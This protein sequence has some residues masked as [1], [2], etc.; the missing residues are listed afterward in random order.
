MY[1]YIFATLGFGLIFYGL[2]PLSGSKPLT[3]YVS[4]YGCLSALLGIAA[5]TIIGCV[6]VL[7]S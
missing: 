1:S 4:E 3:G 2:S 7:G 5:L 6:K